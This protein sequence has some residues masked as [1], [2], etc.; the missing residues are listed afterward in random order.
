M[1]VNESLGLSFD[2]VLLVPRLGVLDHRGDADIST[3]LIEHVPLRIPIISAPMDSVTG[4][5]MAI[6]MNEE[7]CF[8]Y[9]PY[10]SMHLDD[11]ISTYHESGRSGAAIGAN[12]GYERYKMLLHAGC[13]YF[14]VDV[15]HAHTVAVAKF[16]EGLPFRNEICLMVGNIA[17]AEAAVFMN[18]LGVDSVKVG[19][20]PGAAC[21]TRET[22]GFGVP[23]L[24]AIADV[25]TAL[26]GT[27]V[28]VVADGGIRNAGDAVKA[29]AAGADS[30]MLGRLLAGADESPYP[31]FYWGMASKKVNGHHAPEGVEG[32]VP[33][34]GPVSNTLKNLAWGIR[35]GLSYAGAINL[36][37]LRENAEF[38]LVSPLSI[39]ESRARI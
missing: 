2:D 19:I 15:A 33:T 18:E 17:T 10:R 12:D 34:T 20:G 13:K 27:G 4:V 1:R 5:A 37:E 38:R 8:G 16:I 25:S 21:I 22:T 32:V 6:A 36:Q 7:G 24:S 29:L 35:S 9:I 26:Y 31:G 30:V 3:R 23:Q 28:T 11:I 14:V 39:A